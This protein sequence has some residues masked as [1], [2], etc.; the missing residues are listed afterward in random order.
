MRKSFG[1][2][3]KLFVVSTAELRG[4]SMSRIAVEIS[5][6]IGY[7]ESAIRKIYTD[8]Y[9]SA[10]DN[11][12]VLE[13]LEYFA[14]QRNIG[15]YLAHYAARDFL[16]SW[17]YSW[18]E[19]EAILDQLNIT[20]NTSPP[21]W[22]FPP[23]YF[24][25]HIHRECE[26]VAKDAIREN[27]VT[28]VIKGPRQLGKTE[29]IGILAS[30]AE[31][32]GKYVVSVDLNEI[33][34]DDGVI[35]FFESLARSI[36]HGIGDEIP[37][38][39]VTVPNFDDPY[40]TPGSI[41]TRFITKAIIPQTN[42]ISLF[43]DNVDQVFID[44][45][46]YDTS[47][48]R[49]LRAWYDKRISNPRHPLTRL[50]TI[51]AISTD[52]YLGK[53]EPG[54]PFNVGVKVELEDFTL[55]ETRQVIDQQKLEIQNSEIEDLWK[56]T[57]GHPFLVKDALRQIKNGHL[58]L[59]LS[60]EEAISEKGPFA[61]H[62]RSLWQRVEFSEKAPELKDCILR[63]LEEEQCL[64]EDAIFRLRGAGLIRATQRNEYEPRYQLYVMYFASKFG[65]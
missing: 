47:F 50:D 26:E 53:A 19:V 1:S 40:E 42:Q 41:F 27:G 6:I 18:P 31:E 56:M 58:S 15:V 9:P 57:G 14:E 54:S 52:P 16:Q 28:I 36:V 8:I 17:D 24:D 3:F 61:A 30:I 44:K 39:Q 46:D 38:F 62:L 49:M 65:L 48:F 63:I 13:L 25:G 21:S 7:G 35:I 60:W 45:R 20:A 2:L 22:L 23:D 43:L 34:L 59:P 64:D 5:D 32:S 12:K 4:V 37:D 29:L 10:L 11:D 51:L 33:R 55:D